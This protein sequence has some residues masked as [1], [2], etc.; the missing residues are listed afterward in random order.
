M[1]AFLLLS[2]DKGS[3]ENSQQRKRGEDWVAE[4]EQNARVTMHNLPKNDN[5]AAKISTGE[6]VF[7]KT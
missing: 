1:M 2:G 7:W 6:N 3:P 5:R 4:K